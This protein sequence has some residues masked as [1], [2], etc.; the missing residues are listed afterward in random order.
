MHDAYGTIDFYH[1]IL[2]SL[3]LTLP[4]GHKVSTYQNLLA[5]FSHIHFS[6]SGWNLMWWWINLSWTSWDYFW[7]WVRFIETKDCLKKTPTNVGMHS[8]RALW[9]DLIHTWYDDRSYRHQFC[10]LHFD[11]KLIDLDLD[12]RSQDCEKAKASAVI[13]SKSFQFEWNLVY[14]WGLLVVWWASY[15][16]YLIHSDLKGENPACMIL[17]PPP[18]SPPPK[19]PHLKCWLV[20]IRLQTKFFQTCYIWWKRPL[21][22]TFWCQFGLPRPSFKVT[23]VWEIK[24]FVCL[25]FSQ[26]QVLIWMKLSLLPPPVGLLK[27]MLN[28]FCTILFK[29]ENSADMM[30]YV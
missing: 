7:I 12:S 10:T 15:S 26:I 21:S 20:F 30:L 23:V 25:I 24:N 9:I 6:W 19:K 8:D 5:L 22:P 27:L 29:G 17:Y 16:F 2:L 3:T 4:V 13:I 28:L 1:V 18:P 11:T 14:C